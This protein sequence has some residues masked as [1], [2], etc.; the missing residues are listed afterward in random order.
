M[1]TNNR[2]LGRSYTSYPDLASCRSAAH[3][4]REQAGQ[5]RVALVR[6]SATA[7]RWRL[8]TGDTVVVVASRDYHRRLQAERSASV[9][10]SLLPEAELLELGLQ[11]PRTWS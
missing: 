3:L 10:L 6:S 2:D 4:A 9:M 7:W 1:T 5:M 8:L 11:R